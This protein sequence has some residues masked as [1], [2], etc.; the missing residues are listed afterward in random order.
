MDEQGVE[1]KAIVAN[2]LKLG[3]SLAMAEHIPWLRWMFHWRRR[4]C[5]AWG[6]LYLTMS[7][8][9]LSDRLKV[10]VSVAN[11]L[12]YLHSEYGEPIVHCDLKPSN[13]LFDGDW[14]PHVSDF[15]TARMLGVNL[16]N[17][18]NISSS[19]AFQGTVGYLAP[20]TFFHSSFPVV[21]IYIHDNRTCI[22]PY[23]CTTLG[24][25][26]SPG[27]T[28]APQEMRRLYLLSATSKGFNLTG[29]SDYEQVV[30][31]MKVL[32]DVQELKHDVEELNIT[33]DVDDGRVA[34]TN[35]ESKLA[36]DIE[37]LKIKL[38]KVEA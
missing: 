13:I 24:G 21:D 34:E 17:G 25:R 35:G 5:Q 20:G 3:A 12:V 29:I 9:T 22:V 30:M 10:C 37:E 31:D 14:E 18:S 15:G 28:T 8:W 1:F 16:Q 11:G 19:L 6:T 2:G 36:G 27:L 7:R 33:K 4:I 26:R 32:K 23:L 38:R